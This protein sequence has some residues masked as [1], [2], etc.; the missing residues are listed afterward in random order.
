[1]N[2]E[3]SQQMGFNVLRPEE[4]N[5]GRSLQWSSVGEENLEASM[6]IKEFTDVDGKKRVFE[7]KSFPCPTGFVYEATEIQNGEPKGMRFS[8]LG[9]ENKAEVWRYKLEERL[10]KALKVKHIEYHR[11]SHT[12]TTSDHI[13][14][15]QIRWDHETEGETPLIIVDGKGLTWTELGKTMMTHEGFQFVMKFVDPSDDMYEI[16]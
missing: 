10:K 5:R 9:T 6:N 8:V 15:G 1:M 11:E 14:R 16:E 7:F 4:K 3:K 12:W 13:I 2:K